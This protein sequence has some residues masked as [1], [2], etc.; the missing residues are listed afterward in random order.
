M[1]KAELKKVMSKQNMEDLYLMIAY[2][3][4]VIRNKKLKDK[5][6]KEHEKLYQLNSRLFSKEIMNPYNIAIVQSLSASEQK[7]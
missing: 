6:E 1:A 2:R 5:S 3:L 7:R 4:K